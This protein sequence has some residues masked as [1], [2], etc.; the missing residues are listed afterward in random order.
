MLDN[1]LRN[2]NLSIKKCNFAIEMRKT[3]ISLIALLFGLVPNMNATHLVGGII[4]YECVSGNTYKFTSIRYRDVTGVQLPATFTLTVK[5]TGGGSNISVLMTQV[6]VG[7]VQPGNAN[8]CFT[9]PPTT[10]EEHIYFSANIVLPASSGGYDVSVGSCCRNG[11][12]TNLVGS[13]GQ[14]LFSHIPDP[15]IYPCNSSPQFVNFPP[16]S[17]CSND[18]IYFDHSASDVNGDS[19]SYYLCDGLNQGAAP[20][21]PTVPYSAGYSGTNPISA[22]PPL[23]I[24]PITGILTGQPNLNGL[25]LVT[26]CMD[27]FRNGV[28]IG[29]YRREVQMTIIFCNQGISPT[30]GTNY[31]SQNLGVN[32]IASCNDSTVTFN[33]MTAGGAF[34]LWDFG[35]AGINTDTS[36]QENPTYTYPDTGTYTITLIVN[37]GYPCADTTTA[38]V[39]VYPVID[40]NFSAPS[41]SCAGQPI[42][43][44]DSS[45][46]TFGNINIW[47]WQFGNGFTS[48][49]QHPINIYPNQSTY[50]VRLIVESTKGCRDTVIKPITVFNSPN[51]N[52]GPLKI[53]CEGDSVMLS[54]SVAGATSIIWKPA[55]GLS[56]TNCLTPL[57]SPS[58]N[59][60]YTLVAIGPGG[61]KD[62]STVVVVVSPAPI[63]DAGPDLFLCGIAQ[64]TIFAS[65]TNVGAANKMWSPMTGLSGPPNNLTQIAS[66]NTTTIYTLTV[67][68]NGCTRKDS[69]TVFVNSVSNDAGLDQTICQKDTTLLNGTSTSNTVTFSWAPAALVDNPN[70]KNPKAFPVG[71]TVFT[72][73]VVDTA[74]GCSGQDT[75]IITVNP[76]PPVNAGKDTVVC[77]NTVANLKASGAASFAWDNHPSLSCTNCPSPV[78]SPVGTTTYY[79]TGFDAIGCPNR[80]SVTVTVQPLPTVTVIPAS[81]TSICE[82]TSTPIKATGGAQY[83]WSPS[84]GISCSTCGTT[85]AAPVIS[86]VYTITVTDQFGCSNTGT[87]NIT[88][89]PALPLSISALPG[90]TVCEGDT[91]Q[92]NVSGGTGYTWAPAGSLSNA[93]VANPMAFPKLN[94]TYTVTATDANG[95]PTIDS[96]TINV[97]ILQPGNFCPDAGICFGD[98]YQLCANGFTSYQWSPAATLSNP[99]IANPVA[100]PVVTTVYTVLVA[101]NQG[102]KDTGTVRVTVNPLPVATV[103]PDV[104]IC[105]NGSTTLNAGGGTA[106][107]WGPA[108]SLSNA[109]IPNPV[110]TPLVTTRYFVTVTDANLCSD[111]AS[112]LV[113]VDP[114]PNTDAGI[115][116]N[117]C[118]GDSVQLLA[119]GAASY[120]WSPAGSLSDPNIA[121]PI[122]KP[123]GTRKYYVIGTHANGCTKT[124]S[125]RVIVNNLPTPI[126]SSDKFI[127]QGDST[128]LTASGGTSFQW[129]PGT[130]LSCTG[131]SNPIAF[132][133]NT[134]VY[135]VT[136]TN[137]AGCIANDSVTVNV[138]SPASIGI[139]PDTAICPGNSLQLS[140]SGGQAFTWTPNT[141]IN[142]PN[143]A[144]PVVTPTSPRT[145]SVRVIDSMG[146]IVNAS[147]RVDISTPADPNAGVSS[148]IC[149]GDTVQLTASNGVTYVWSPNDMLDPLVPDPKVSPKTTTT[150]T[151][152]IIDANGCTN[153]GQV[154]I[155]VNPLPNVD[156]G[157]DI[158]IYEGDKAFISATGAKFYLWRPYLYMVDSNVAS[159]YVFPPADMTY[160]VVGTD[161]QGCRNIDSINIFVKE[162]PKFWVPTAFTPNGDGKN[163]YFIIDAWVNFNLIKMSVFNRWGALVFETTDIGRGWDGTF[164][165]EKLPMD[166]YIFIITG[167]DDIDFPVRRQGNVTLIR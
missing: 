70:I 98:S 101:D 26:I 79:V 5:P 122:A 2:Y 46:A 20:P 100:T 77:V 66:P 87:V 89:T 25:F 60:I 133:V 104:V 17:V 165:G 135:T 40:A 51:V 67:T 108:G 91:A 42:Q 11:G 14:T 112:V 76:P 118:K 35:V 71:T 39:I 31:F 82:N 84:T 126:I 36:T 129:T 30:V 48:S 140:V 125:V 1:L 123:T 137:G 155:T 167:Q 32:V 53:V 103:S 117:I 160:Y 9:P 83:L 166:S 3:I 37:P 96:I 105:L 43:F 124:D 85:T 157:V 33:N 113:T 16:L 163:D 59:T 151:V 145:Y 29:T 131:C 55:T 4:Y 143:I 6:S 18:S 62:S 139:T 95:C 116:Q 127:C 152:S 132:P 147:V 22:N 15:G 64:D 121:N 107:T 106:F 24:D 86:T 75:V 94:T 10:T 41:P 28:L 61:C 21:F 161:D 146:C 23:A 12:I 93:Y 74:T 19:I 120:Q 65:V 97:N 144:N 88:V 156:A 90:T 164:N 27:E 52:A 159:T 49:Q 45:S 58:T 73:S 56:C 114:L 148:T 158:N 149:I 47:N 54:G 142:D 44:I 63:V 102:C 38:T 8:P 111:T 69:V 34:Y 141:E 80:D 7:M 136:I 130:G 57:A 115:D 72:L 134:T 13:P 78:A 92:L 162:K 68:I 128:I 81:G 154:T 50:N 109:L 150:Y 110:A 119:T 153:S 99:N 138:A